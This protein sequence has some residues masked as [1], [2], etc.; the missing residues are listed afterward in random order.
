MTDD[1]GQAGAAPAYRPVELSP[2]K[3]VDPERV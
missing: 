1:Q 3:P 2:P